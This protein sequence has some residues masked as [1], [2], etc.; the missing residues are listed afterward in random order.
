MVLDVNGCAYCWGWNRFGQCADNATNNVS[1]PKKIKFF[2]NKR[3]TEIS[4]GG[5]H[6]YA[7]TEDGGHYLFGDNEYNTCFIFEEGWDKVTSPHQVNRYIQQSVGC[8]EILE[9]IPGR[10]NNVIICACTEKEN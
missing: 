1:L 2:E 5:F 8:D 6:C 9:V 10:E 7:K 4:C 3:V